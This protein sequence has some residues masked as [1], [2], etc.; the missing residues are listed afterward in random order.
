M[1]TVLAEFKVVRMD[2]GLINLQ[3]HLNGMTKKELLSAQLQLTDLLGRQA[4]L[5]MKDDIEFE[6]SKGEI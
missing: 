4:R 5:I 3:Y 6:Y 2:N 1:P